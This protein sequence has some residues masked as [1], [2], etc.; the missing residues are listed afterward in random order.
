MITQRLRENLTLTFLLQLLCTSLTLILLYQEVVTYTVTRPT[1]SSSE[2]TALEDE[3]FPKVTFCLDPALSKA[4]AKRYGYDVTMYYRGEMKVQQNGFVGWNGVAT[5]ESSL[6]ILED[7]LTLKRDMTLFKAWYTGDDLH[8]DKYIANISYTKPTYPIGRCFVVS[9]FQIKPKNIETMVVL[10]PAIYSGFVAEFKPSLN[11][12]LDD[13]ANSIQVYPQGFQ[14][15]GS[16]IKMRLK[17][18]ISQQSSYYKFIYKIKISRS[19]HVPGDSHQDCTEYSINQTYNDCV[20]DE[21]S[22]VFLQAIGCVPPL[23]AKNTNATCNRVLNLTSV[24]GDVISHL[25]YRIYSVGFKSA[26]CKTPCTTTTFTTELVTKTPYS[27]DVFVLAFDPVVSVTR[28]SFSISPQTL[29]TRL[30]GSVSS[31][32]TLLW[33]LAALMAVLAGIKKG[34]ATCWRAMSGRQAVNEG[35]D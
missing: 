26:N 5:N 23:L 12:H 4:N 35:W 27:V 14:M 33:A 32:R 34:W 19:Y 2:Q 24:E 9:P 17:A 28:T 25:L 30:G 20:Q 18:N 7:I 29:V 15:H 22:N 3:T 13:P 8:G 11:V 16:R 21:I 10:I 31:G 6:D 1:M